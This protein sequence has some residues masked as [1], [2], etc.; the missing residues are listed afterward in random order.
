M[1]RTIVVALYGVAVLATAV[2]SV[3]VDDLRHLSLVTMVA[4]FP[5]SA[6]DWPMVPLMVLVGGLNAWLLW[7]ALHVRRSRERGVRW[8]RRLIYAEVFMDLIGAWA[9]YELADLVDDTLAENGTSIVSLILGLAVNLLLSLA[10]TEA[11]RAYRV[12]LVVLALVVAV[13]WWV[14][15]PP[16]AAL[17]QVVLS[18]AWWFMILLA[19]RRDGRWSATTI[20]LGWCAVA[21]SLVSWVLP[22]MWAQSQPMET[23]FVQVLQGIMALGVVRLI[24][25]MRTAAEAD[26]RPVA[27]TRE[28]TIASA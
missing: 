17:A 2:V 15:L 8:L 13:P 3:V 19:Q 9:L 22:F 20:G 4:F 23:A 27:E 28:T 6:L 5:P 1:I 26:R 24:W 16:V 14:F 7:E 10:L 12:T 18:Q 25:S 11:S 21:L